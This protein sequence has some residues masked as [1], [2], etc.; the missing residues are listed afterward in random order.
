MQVSTLTRRSTTDDPF[1]GRVPATPLDFLDEDGLRRSLDGAGVL[2]NTYWV[3]YGRGHTTFDAAVKNSK[4]L[5]E[6]AREAG[7][8]RIVHIS[9]VQPFERFRPAILQGQWPT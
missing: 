4:R 9:V 2:Y 3:R 7:V 6:A 5:F 1:G 8:G